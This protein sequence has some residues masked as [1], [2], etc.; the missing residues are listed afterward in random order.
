MQ[1]HHVPLLS[2]H[3]FVAQPTRVP[4]SVRGFCTVSI[5][6]NGP[7]LHRG[8]GKL[9]QCVRTGLVRDHVY[10]QVKRRG[11]HYGRVRL[12]SSSSSSLSCSCKNCTKNVSTGARWMEMQ[13]TNLDEGLRSLEEVLS[14]LRLRALLVPVYDGL[15][16]NTVL[17]VQNLRN[18][19][20][21]TTAACSTTSDPP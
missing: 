12:H 5:G 17:V 13:I 16:R 15:I 18:R 11:I 21:S 7:A 8:D 3:C 9:D 20:R 6:V 4:C 19:P 14:A 1:R 2:C 10:M